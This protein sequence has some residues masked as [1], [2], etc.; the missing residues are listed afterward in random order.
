MTAA[1]EQDE[2]SEAFWSV[3]RC[4]TASCFVSRTY[5][6]TVFFFDCEV[7]LLEFTETCGNDNMIGLRAHASLTNFWVI[8]WDIVHKF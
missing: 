5:I 6:D 8:D 7:M 2:M 3:A 4:V 1:F